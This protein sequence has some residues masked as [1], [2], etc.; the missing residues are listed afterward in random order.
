[1]ECGQYDYCIISVVNTT[2]CGLDTNALLMVH[3]IEVLLPYIDW[4]NGVMGVS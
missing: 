1:L 2:L 3:K 4:L